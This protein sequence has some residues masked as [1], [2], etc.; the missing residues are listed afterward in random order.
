MHDS[1][2]PQPRSPM[3]RSHGR[4]SPYHPRAP[5]SVPLDESAM[6][7]HF[8]DPSP[9]A[10]STSTVKTPDARFD[11]KELHTLLCSLSHEL[12]RPLTSL[13]SGFDLLIADGP[14]ADL[15]AADGPR[16][17]DD[18]PLRRV[19]P[20]DPGLPRLRGVGPRVA[21]AQAGDVFDR[22]DR[23]RTRPPVRRPCAEPRP[24]LARGRR[25]TRRDGRH[26]RLTVSASVRQP[27]LQRHQI[28]SAGRNRRRLGLCRGRHLASDRRRRRTG[29]P[30]RR[31]RPDFRAV[32]PASPSTSIPRSRGPDWG[33]RSA[34][35]WPS[36][37]TAGSSSN[38]RKAAAPP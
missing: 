4:S 17:D 34:A 6:D 33:C 26:R 18:G 14:G 23:P 16:H 37:F 25:R 1:G 27:R 8:D 24:D 31:R 38:P 30:R 20:P 32:L 11:R 36:S 7:A 22:C 29:R 3:R 28:H 9:S 35:S 12:C 10:S 2:D 21:N 15:P 5:G 13:R 19:A